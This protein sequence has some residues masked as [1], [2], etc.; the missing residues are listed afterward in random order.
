MI[1]L[2][3]DPVF[4]FR[5]VDD[6]IVPRFHLDGVDSGRRVIVTDPSGTR[7]ATG[8]VGD[9]GWVDLA[10]PLIVPAGSGFDVRVGEGVRQA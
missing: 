6:R 10:E 5:F 8:I 1:R 9:G 2:Y 3:E 4:R 7:L